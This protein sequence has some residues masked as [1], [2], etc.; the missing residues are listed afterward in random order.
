MK[1]CGSR[2]GQLLAPEQYPLSRLLSSQMNT[3]LPGLHSAP[4][5]TEMD[6]TFKN[7]FPTEKPPEAYARLLLDVMRGDHAQFV[8][9]DEL[10]AAW[11]IFS[12]LLHRMERE[13]VEPF[14]YPFGSRGPPASDEL[15]KRCGYQYDLRYSAKWKLAEGPR[16]LDALRDSFRLSVSFC[17]SLSASPAR[18]H[19][20]LCV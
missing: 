11:A 5:E 3:K 4:V 6:I 18:S 10:E 17:F 13:R 7:R 2:F 9:S 16:A 1:P 12:P 19:G 15:I 14:A 20:C 8:R